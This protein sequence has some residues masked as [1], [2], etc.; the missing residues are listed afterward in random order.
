MMASKSCTPQ[1]PFLYSDAMISPLAFRL[2]ILDVNNS[3]FHLIRFGFRKDHKKRGLQV[4][5]SIYGQPF[6]LA[7][8]SLKRGW[9]HIRDASCMAKLHWPS[10]AN[11][12]IP[13]I[14]EQ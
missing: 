1:S 2:L 6:F 7:N 4:C 5:L 9:P 12:E 3:G 14:I 13:K 10:K 11:L 8:R